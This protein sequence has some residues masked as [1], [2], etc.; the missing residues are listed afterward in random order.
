MLKLIGKSCAKLGYA[1]LSVD[2][3]RRADGIDTTNDGA[4]S[5]LKIMAISPEGVAARCDDDVIVDHRYGL[6]AIPH[7][8][9]LYMRHVMFGGS[10][11][12]ASDS[13]LPSQGGAKL[14]IKIFDRVEEARP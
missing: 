10:F 7:A 8:R 14:P 1:G 9:W 6:R 11:C 5:R 2:V 13:R 12:F 4:S 3:Y